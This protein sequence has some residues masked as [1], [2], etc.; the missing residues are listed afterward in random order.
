[1]PRLGFDLP[2]I[3]AHNPHLVVGFT[4]A[5]RADEAFRRPGWRS[6]RH[7]GRLPIAVVIYSSI[8]PL[9]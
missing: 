2:A 7:L 1:L 6:R 5:N 9:L 3:A 8:P 4:A